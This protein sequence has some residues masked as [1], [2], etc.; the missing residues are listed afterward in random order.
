MK[1]LTQL[2]YQQIFLCLI[3]KHILLNYEKYVDALDKLILLAK[4]EVFD[5]I[6][7]MI[8]NR[9]TKDGTLFYAY[10]HITSL[11]EKLKI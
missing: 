7:Q 3:A 6:E 11:K 2:E 8:R 9:I 5:D 1:N 4:K 10:L